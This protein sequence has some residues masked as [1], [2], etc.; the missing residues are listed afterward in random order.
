[1]TKALGDPRSDPSDQFTV[2]VRSGSATGTVLNSATHSTTTGTGAAV[3]SGSGTTG[4]TAA[5][6]THTYYVTESQAAGSKSKA[7]QY[8]AA[9]SCTDTNNLQTGLPT[10]APFTASLAIVPVANAAISCTL[11]NT[12]V[13]PTIVVNTQLGSSRYNNSDQF[14]E[15]VR[16]GGANGTIV[17]DQTHAPTAGS[18]QAVDSGTG[19]TGVYTGT[20]GTTYTVTDSFTADAGKY[21]ST[22]SCADANGYQPNLPNNAPFSGSLDIALVA[23]AAVSCTIV[24]SVTPES[25]SLTKSGPTT[26]TVGAVATYTVTAADVSAG[27]VD[28]TAMAGATLPGCTGTRGDATCPVVTSDPSSTHTPVDKPTL[29]FTGTDARGQLLLATVIILAGLGLVVVGRRRRSAG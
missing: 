28:N 19:T 3:D 8:T 14:T 12:P 25:L 27:S 7:A 1:V 10:N 6:V 18:G 21:T 24:H 11:T 9:I 15:A 13:S 17:S 4:A 29:P 5:T 23:G 16:T 22:I 20:S 2:A 26:M